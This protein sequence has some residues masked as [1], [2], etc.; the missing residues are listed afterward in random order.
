MAACKE[1]M[2]PVGLT[3]KKTRNKYGPG[4]G[5]LMLIHRCTDCGK[6]SINRIAADDD[7]ERILEIYERSVN[8]DWMIGKLGIREETGRLDQ[9]GI[10]LLGPSDRGRVHARLFGRRPSA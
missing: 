8:G 5:E 2:Q 7:A 6:L 10:R 4:W 3:L 9:A 1:K